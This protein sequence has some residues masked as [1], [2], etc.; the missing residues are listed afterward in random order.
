MTS[1]RTAILISA[2]CLL[3]CS[4]KQPEYGDYESTVSIAYLKSLCRGSSYAITDDISICGSVVANDRL[5]EFYKSI[6]I[7]DD[8]GGIEVSIDKHDIYL[9]LPL[10]S[11][12]TIFCSGLSLGRLG[13]KI[14]LG[15]H[16]TGN[17]PVDGI[18][19]DQFSHYFKTEAS[20]ANTSPVER[21]IGSLTA[22]DISSYVVFRNLHLTG[23][24]H[25]AWCATE[26]GE[27]IDTTHTL[28]DA[29]GTTLPLRV[30]A[31]CSYAG[32]PTPSSTFD[33]AGIVDYADG[34]YFLR[35]SNYAV[36]EK[37]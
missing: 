34:A 9:D 5:G 17:Y 30:N 37:R 32:M 10:H 6:V 29:S 4:P 3:G 7:V 33:I 11:R 14:E 36:S 1:F 12:I 19:A 25:D 22:A 28:E 21:T 23:E 35:I 27:W 20:G 26:N 24:Q 13:G 8:S 15:A 16:P 2:L 31:E 18:S